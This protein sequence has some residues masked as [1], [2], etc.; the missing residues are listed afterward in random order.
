MKKS[1]TDARNRKDYTLAIIS[2]YPIE[3]YLKKGY[4]WLF[5]YYNPLNFFG[6][7]HFFEPG[8]GKTVIMKKPYT[9]YIHRTLDYEEVRKAFTKYKIDCIRTY[10]MSS[11]DLAKRLS[12]EFGA[13]LVVSIH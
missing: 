4:D 11:F 7:L 13:P 12:E 3:G 8:D 9:L 6:G 2:N 10:E 5:F 1:L